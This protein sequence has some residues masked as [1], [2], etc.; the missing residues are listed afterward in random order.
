M[1]QFFKRPGRFNVAFCEN[2]TALKK[3]LLAACI[4]PLNPKCHKQARDI[5]FLK[6]RRMEEE[7]SNSS[8][9]GCAIDSFPSPHPFFSKVINYLQKLIILKSLTK[10]R[11][12]FFFSTRSANDSQ[13]THSCIISW[14]YFQTLRN[15]DRFS[16]CSV[17]LAALCQ[18]LLKQTSRSRM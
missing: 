5:F 16:E 2:L 12:V 15:I 4:C 18:I 11:N 6:K 3:P 17:A 14:M 9:A 13:S 7:R 10:L 8:G 1:D